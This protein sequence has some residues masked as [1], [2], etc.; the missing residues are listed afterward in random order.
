MVLIQIVNT[1]VKH[2]KVADNLK[3][4]KIQVVRKS[5]VKKV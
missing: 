2:L 4:K 1:F 3:H 5:Y